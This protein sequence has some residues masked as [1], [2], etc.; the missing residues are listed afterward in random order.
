[1]ASKWAGTFYRQIASASELSSRAKWGN[2]SS[3]DLREALF[4]LGLS[5][6]GKKADLFARLLE[7]FGA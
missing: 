3:A 1:M 2:V 4:F 7:A 5:E 6:K